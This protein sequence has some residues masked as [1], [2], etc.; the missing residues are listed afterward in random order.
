MQEN[1]LHAEERPPDPVMRANK[2]VRAVVIAVGIVAA[3][4]GAAAIRW[5]LPYGEQYV[6]K[7]EPHA[8]LR[9][10]QI[11]VAVLFLSVLPLGA[12][13]FWF[14]YRAVQSHQIPPPGTWVI[15]DT[16]VV[17][18]PRARQR[19]QI[20]MALGVLLFALGLSGAIYFPDRLGRV[21][22]GAPPQP[23]AESAQPAQT[24]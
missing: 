23:A 7:Q 9:T 8:A 24:R 17:E 5:L 1:E 22:Q 19:G 18:G 4:M 16:K 20:V 2:T 11:L 3:L 10:M 13:V 6:S 14:G 15:R 21:F 12:Y